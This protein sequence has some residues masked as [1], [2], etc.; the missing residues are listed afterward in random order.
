MAV[1]ADDDEIVC[2]HPGGPRV[3]GAAA[4]RASFEAIF[5]NGG[6]PGA[7][8]AGAPAAAPGLRRAPPGRAH[9][10][11]TAEG[12]AGGLGAGHQ[13]L[14]EDAAGLAHG[15]APR[16]PRPRRRSPRA[17]ARPS[18]PPRCIAALATMQGYRA[19]AWLPG[20]N[21]QTIWAG[22]AR[23]ATDGPP[24]RW[25]RERWATPDGDFIDVDHLECP[26]PAGPTPPRRTWCCSTAWKAAAP[27]LRAG[28]RAWPASAA[29]PTACRTSAAARASSTWR[30]APTT[31]ATSRRSAGSCSAC[32]R[33]RRAAAG[34]GR[35]AGRQRAAALGRRRPA[36]ARGHRRRRGRRVLAHR[37]GRRRPAI[38]RGFNRLR[39]TRACSCQHEAQGPGQVAAAPGL[40]DRGAW[41]RR[42]PVRVRRRLHRAAARLR[43]TPDYW[44]ALGGCRTWRASASRPWC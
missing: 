5:A 30:R 25:R 43:G 9:R 4:I 11:A 20:G 35:L 17:P 1:W 10:G 19:R 29:G 12:P 31:R 44:R 24:P 36:T 37:P 2:V 38:D 3:V 33:A 8:R 22:A 27:A 16:Q 40:F 26:P 34:G 6:I 15:R 32:A 7:A 21:L 41:P 42:A 23:S 14:R 39:S 13:R 28:L 18:G